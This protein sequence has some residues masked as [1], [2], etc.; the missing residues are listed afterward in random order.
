MFLRKNSH[1]KS[2]TLPIAASFFFIIIII[3]FYLFIYLFFKFLIFISF[4]KLTDAS[5]SRPYLVPDMQASDR[6]GIGKC[7]RILVP[8]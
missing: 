8:P 1:F 3:L 7:C 6:L 2:T 4:S 5:Y